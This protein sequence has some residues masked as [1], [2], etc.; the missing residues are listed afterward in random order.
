MVE[1]NYLVAPLGNEYLE[2]TESLY[3]HIVLSVITF[4]P[5]LG[6]SVRWWVSRG[7]PMPAIP[8]RC[9]GA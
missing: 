5:R 7:S 1:F 9:V 6:S 2:G 8:C 3:L 4:I